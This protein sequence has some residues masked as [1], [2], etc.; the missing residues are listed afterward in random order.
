MVLSRALCDLGAGLALVA[1]A[2]WGD[3]PIEHTQTDS[4]MA[5][6]L[7]YHF[8]TC[9]AE[10][11]SLV[12]S[13]QLLRSLRN[14]FVAYKPHLLR[15]H[16]LVCGI[17]S[18]LTALLWATEGYGVGT[19]RFCWMNEQ[20][21]PSAVSFYV[22]VIGMFAFGLFALVVATR[23][24]PALSVHAH[25]MR[26]DVLYQCV[27]YTGAFIT[28]ASIEGCGYA[29]LYAMENQENTAVTALQ[30]SAQASTA[31]VSSGACR[32][33]KQLL[34]GGTCWLTY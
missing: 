8:A 23:G 27:L 7:C 12:F 5:I 11:W 18:G 33:S 19:C 26:Q 4:C 15:S 20:W 1:A 10:G 3:L 21:G 16:A 6:A 22:P 14:P 17:A 30:V 31:T 25:R 34:D 9:A 13:I 32:L 24:W 28:Y 2:V 29:L